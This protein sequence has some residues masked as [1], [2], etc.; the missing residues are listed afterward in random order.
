MRGGGLDLD[1][2]DRL[3]GGKL[4]IFDVPCPLCGPYKSNRGQRR[5]V[6]R[7]YRTEP[8]FAGYHCARCGEAGYARDRHAPSPDPAELAKACAEAAK[9]DQI[10]KADRLA[11]ARWLWSQHKPIIGSVAERYLRETRKIGCPLP[12]T[13]GFLPARGEYPAAM[14]AAYGLGHEIEPAVIAI[15]D[16]AIRGVHLTRLLPDGSDR[17]RGEQA[18][19]MIGQSIGT[20]IILAAPNDLLGMAISEG[21]E[22][23][24]TVHEATGLGTWAA[25][26]ASRL[27]ALADAVPDHIEAVTV[28]TDD[29]MD[30]RRH[31]AAL[32]D[33]LRSRCIETRQVIANKWPAVA[34]V[35]H[36]GGA[37]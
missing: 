18:K 12:A 23:A 21:I 33:R 9:R 22:D 35:P 7:V 31:A 4:G 13:L 16:D 11:K 28:L 37:S 8:G 14:I 30:G 27:P 26:S 3:T 10:H 5:C 19:I 17:E 20:P 24:L 32:V 25:G 29:D 36:D 34:G 1:T 6:L 2:V 15:A